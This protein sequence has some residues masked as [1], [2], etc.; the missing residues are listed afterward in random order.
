[1]RASPSPRRGGGGPELCYHDRKSMIHWFH[2]AVMCSLAAGLLLAGA[3]A[4]GTE[5]YRSTGE[6]GE[7]VFSDQPSPGA[8][9][10]EVEP[11][12]AVDLEPPPDPEPPAGGDR[13]RDE[14]SP[15]AGFA[16]TTPA[17]GE[18]VRTN[19]GEVTVGLS[20]PPDLGE[21]RA[22]RLYLDGALAAETAP[23]EAVTLANV[24]RGTHRLRAALVDGGGREL[25]SSGTV[26]F[27]VLRVSAITKP[28]G[29]DV[30]GGAGPAPAEGGSP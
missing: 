17:E 2:K 9:R 28:P 25:A 10:I 4:V 11:A 8:E 21:D 18:G 22:V 14:G 5:V 15:Y 1:M 27:H 26:T 12:P 16:I 29:P 7:P 23:T 6:A 20:L 3:T 24:D 13:S 30:P 19:A